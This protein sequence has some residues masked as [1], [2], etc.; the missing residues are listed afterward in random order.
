M[1]QTPLPRFI[2]PP[3]SLCICNLPQALQ[4]ENARKKMQSA[5]L[6]ANAPKRISPLASLGVYTLLYI[7]NRNKRQGLGRH[8]LGMSSAEQNRGELQSFLSL[9]VCWPE[10]WSTL[11]NT[12][13]WDCSLSINLVSFPGPWT[14]ADRGIPVTELCRFLNF[15]NGLSRPVSH[16]GWAKDVHP[17][18][19]PENTQVWIFPLTCMVWLILLFKKKYLNFNEPFIL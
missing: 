18:F 14:S 10:L 16:C 15:V 3:P 12:C 1:L 13:V 4:V 11:S 2:P 19:L 6:I 17:C 5:Q 9:A 7:C 8:E